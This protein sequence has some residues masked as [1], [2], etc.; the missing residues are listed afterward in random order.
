MMTDSTLIDIH[1]LPSA[2]TTGAA[3]LGSSL[4][5]VSLDE[6]QRI[7]ARRML[8]YFG[9]DKVRAAELLGVSRSTLYRL[10]S[11][12]TGLRREAAGG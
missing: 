7:H 8:D 4:D 5:V 2:V 3:P 12:D 6:I 11:E 9:G 1:H 10:L